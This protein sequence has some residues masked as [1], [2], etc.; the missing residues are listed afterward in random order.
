MNEDK[1]PSQV[2][3]RRQH[4]ECEE[5]GW[6]GRD[7]ETDAGQCPECGGNVELIKD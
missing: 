4:Y 5:C 2:V 1:K 3:P 7:D 6:Q